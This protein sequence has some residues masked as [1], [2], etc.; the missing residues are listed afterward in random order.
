MT[1]TVVWTENAINELLQLWPES[2]SRA[3]I[4]RAA[5]AIDPTLRIDPVLRGETY[6]ASTRLLTIPP[7][8]VLYRIVEE[9]RLVRVL[10]IQPAP[11]SP[12]QD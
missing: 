6:T 8:L 5:D 3:L 10:S 11:P 12:A 7:L 4:T 1:Y 9:D 2:S